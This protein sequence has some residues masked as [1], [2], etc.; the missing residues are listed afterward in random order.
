MENKVLITLTNPIIEQLSEKV[1]GEL[2]VFQKDTPVTITENIWKSISNKARKELII[3]KALEV[4]R[5]YP[6]TQLN[7]VNEDIYETL[8]V[9]KVRGCELEHELELFAKDVM[10]YD[11]SEDELVEMVICNED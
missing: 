7:G 5:R 1:V 4:S 2:S 6:N 3:A 8:V 9:E 11:Y 10:F